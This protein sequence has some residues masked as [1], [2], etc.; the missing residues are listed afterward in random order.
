ML[1]INAKEKSEAGKENFCS[2]DSVIPERTQPPNP[3][4]QTGCFQSN[5]D[6]VRLNQKGKKKGFVMGYEFSENIIQC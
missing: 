6:F 4:M 1:V 5:Q 3:K 2:T